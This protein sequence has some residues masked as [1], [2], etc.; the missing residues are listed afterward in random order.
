MLSNI[1]LPP[2]E[3]NVY[4]LRRP[5]VCSRLLGTPVNPH[6][7]AVVTPTVSMLSP[8]RCTRS[9]F[10][11]RRLHENVSAGAAYSSEPYG[12]AT[13]PRMTMA[14]QRLLA[15]SF[16]CLLPDKIRCTPVSPTDTLLNH[17]SPWPFMCPR[18]VFPRSLARLDF[19]KQKYSSE[20]HG[21]TTKPRMTM[22]VQCALALSFLLFCPSFHVSG[23]WVCLYVLCRCAREA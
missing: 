20:P 15:L 8:S 5:Q 1:L 11:F 18:S 21:Y 4:S 16:R 19:A 3:Q 9:V 17:A 12:F 23:K 7:R 22:A 6:K 13:K 14:V 2:T 10:P